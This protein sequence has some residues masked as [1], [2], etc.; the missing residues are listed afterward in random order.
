MSQLPAEIRK[1]KQWSY[2]HSVGSLKRPRHSHYTPNGSMSFVDALQKARAEGLYIGFY[3]THEDPYILGDIDHISNPMSK[4]VVGTELPIEISDILFNRQVYS[5][6]SPSGKG[7]RFIAK[8]SEGVKATL[9]GRYFKNHLPMG[10]STDEVDEKGGPLKREAQFHIGPPWNTITGNKTPYSGDGIVELRL[11]ELEPIFKIRY[12]GE[13]VTCDYMPPPDEDVGRLPALSE[14][15]YAL[16]RLPWDGNPR[17][18][19]AFKLTFD[20]EEY[21]PYEYWLKVMMA[22]SDYASRMTA[23][24]NV[25][26][27][28]MENA[29]KWSAKDPNGYTGEKDVIDKWRSFMRTEKKVSF[30]T[31]MSLNHYYTLRWPQCKAPSKA[32]REAGVTTPQPLVAQYANFESLVRFYNMVLY[33]DSNT[34]HKLYLTGDWDFIEKYFRHLD[35]RFYFEKY[36]GPWTIKTLVPV[37]HFVLQEHGF[38]NLSQAQVHQHVSIW[39]SRMSRTIDLV[40]LYFDTPYDQLPDDYKENPAHLPLSTVEKL[41]DCLDIDYMTEDVTKERQLYFKYYKSWLMGLARNIFFP[42]IQQMNNCVLLL[43]GN[44]Q[45]RKTSHF[46]YILPKF[47]REDRVAFSGH[48][49]GSEAAVR[50]VTKIAAM[51]NLIV[52]DEI[53]QYLTADTESNFKKLIDNNPIKVIDKYEV[54]DSYVKPIAIYGATSNLREFPLSDNGSRRLF[55][56]PVKW[57]DTDTMDKVNWHRVINDLRYEIEASDPAKPPWLLDENALAY[58]AT[59]HAKITAKSSLDLIVEEMFDF[60]TP[61]PVSKTATVIDNMDFRK[62]SFLWT[63][64]DVA[65]RIRS[66][67]PGMKSFTR[68]HLVNVLHRVC[69]RWTN[70]MRN[71]REFKKPKVVIT[72][73]EVFFGGRSKFWMPP[74]ITRATRPQY[75]NEGDI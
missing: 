55:H 28:C 42:D 53:E 59:L 43:T 16:H 56:I 48:G 46:Q 71:S 13:E 38:I 69:G 9:E 1:L 74:L 41:F 70:T 60:A 3:V 23:D 20:G 8:L 32:Q 6:A 24:P 49:F 10:Y 25:Q 26:S 18:Q 64:A 52:W 66:T 27:S 39:I 50:D 45:I 47:M 15:L 75:F 31:L 29:V 63:A 68:K 17:I 72:K 2:S 61:W 12:V 14:I 4:E 30:H 67:N 11:D 7:I 34:P 65:T 5:E 19:R 35:T 73:G 40:K 51:N 57:V 62:S 54:V 58:Q 44:E 36:H 21:T 22:M 37:M 33:R